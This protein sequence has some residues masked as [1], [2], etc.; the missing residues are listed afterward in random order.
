VEGNVFSAAVALL[1]NG[2]LRA[3]GPSKKAGVR[4][5][6]HSRRHRCVAVDGA[7]SGD[8]DLRADIGV[9]ATGDSPGEDIE[10]DDPSVHA[11]EDLELFEDLEVDERMREDEGAEEKDHVE[12]DLP[13]PAELAADDGHWAPGIGVRIP[14]MAIPYGCGYFKQR[15][16]YFSIDVHC[17]RCF[18]KVDKTTRPFI[19]LAIAQTR[20]TPLLPGKNAS[21]GRPMGGHCRLLE[22]CPGTKDA[23]LALIASASYDDCKRSRTRGSADP[24]LEGMF[25]DE[26]SGP[27]RVH[28]GTGGGPEPADGPSGEPY[29]LC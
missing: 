8:E 1:P 19:G 7:G 22:F 25:A 9:E 17:L 23:H 20:T 10:R 11:D 24:T 3:A 6:A 4:R 21:Q 16:D 13:P 18:A 14:R 28:L 27:H 5:R 29:H 2:T 26:D 12:V 15:R